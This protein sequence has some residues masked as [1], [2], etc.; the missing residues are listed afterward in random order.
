MPEPSLSFKFVMAGVFCAQDLF[1]I[2][3]RVCAIVVGMNPDCTRISVSTAELEPNDGDML[4]DKVC[5]LNEWL[6]VGVSAFIG[7]RCRKGFP[8]VYSAC[9]AGDNA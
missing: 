1:A 3:E 8:E 4:K 5:L 7:H 6:L 2:G 9:S